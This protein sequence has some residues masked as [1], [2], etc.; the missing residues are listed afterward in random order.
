MKKF[1][2]QDVVDRLKVERSQTTLME[3][4]V[5]YG[6]SPERIR[7]ILMKEARRLRRNGIEYS[8]SCRICGFRQ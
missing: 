3:L 1:W 6:V 7:Q 5:R 8:E 2:T 4:G